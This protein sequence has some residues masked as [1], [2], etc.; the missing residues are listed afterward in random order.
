MKLLRVN[1][2]WN[3]IVPQVLGWIYFSMLTKVVYLTQNPELRGTTLTAK[4]DIT[5]YV[6][7]FLA[8]ISIAAFGYLLNDICDIESDTIAGKPNSLTRFT[9]MWRLDRK[10]TR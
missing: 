3:T 8:L 6:L 7:F 4:T 5:R 9:P 10:S 1:S 2:W